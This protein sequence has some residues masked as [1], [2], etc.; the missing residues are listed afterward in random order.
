MNY[1]I[2]RHSETYFSK[3]RLSYGDNIESAPILKEGIPV[4]KKLGKYLAKQNIDLYFT[5]P[6]KRSLQTAEIIQEITGKKFI[7]DER[8]SEEKISRRKESH[9]DLEKRLRSF[10]HEIKKT[11]AKSIAIC[12]HGWPIAA[13]SAIITKDAV[14]LKDLDN[15]PLSGELIIIKNK[16]VR[17]IS[18]R[19]DL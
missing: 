10:L 18:F 9:K 5:S 2:F 17:K 12:S 11:K 7:I 4:M 14:S 13:L 6:Y 15:Y 3:N 1:F 19:D 8:L 16:K